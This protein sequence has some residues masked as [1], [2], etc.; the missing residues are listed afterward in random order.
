M[1]Y[2]GAIIPFQRIC[3]SSRGWG[4]HDATLSQAVGDAV[5][6]HRG[7]W[8]TVTLGMAKLENVKGGECYKGHLVQARI[9]QGWK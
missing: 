4:R 3:K 6:K 5:Y 2:L 1:N 7:R 8:A 9:S